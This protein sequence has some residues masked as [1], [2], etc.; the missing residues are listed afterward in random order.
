MINVT[1]AGTLFLLMVCPSQEHPIEKISLTGTWEIEQYQDDGRDRLDRLGAGPA[2]KNREKRTAKLVFSK[3]ECWII[4][5]D[6]RREMASGL[7]NA[8]FKSFAVNSTKVPAEID[9]TGFSGK[10]NSKTRIYPGIIRIDGDQLTICYCEQG[11][12]RP[13]A[14]KSD[15]ANNLFVAK[16]IS[17]V[18]QKVPEADEK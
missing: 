16:R 7:A 15:G 1:L 14:F 4:R 5:G 8:G 3:Q 12:T 18:A 2:R 11:K 6:G 9:I 13:E 17:K 10:E